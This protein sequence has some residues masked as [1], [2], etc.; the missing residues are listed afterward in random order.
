MEFIFIVI[1][2]IFT[3]FCSLVWP[4]VSSSRFWSFQLVVFVFLHSIN[5]E[6]ILWGALS[7]GYP[8]LD[9][10]IALSQTPLAILVIVT[11]FF[12]WKWNYGLKFAKVHLVWLLS[13]S[14]FFLHPIFM[15]QLLEGSTYFELFAPEFLV[16]YWELLFTLLLHH[17]QVFFTLW[18]LFNL[19]MYYMCWWR[20]WY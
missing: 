20:Q 15:Y 8:T 2:R 6:F 9:E 7:R 14:W 12:R 11:Q 5:F 4:W 17:W 16:Y 18:V 10:S 1:I 13:L 19:W 3:W